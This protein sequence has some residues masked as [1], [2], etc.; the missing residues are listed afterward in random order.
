MRKLEK[1]EVV[2]TSV[3][4]QR[5]NRAVYEFL[6]KLKVGDRVVIDR[7]DWKGKTSLVHTLHNVPL[8]KNKFQCR[9]LVDKSGWEVT[10]VK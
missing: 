7:E 4:G 6:L 10:K 1:Y 2:Q 9:L 3:Q 8:F 5:V